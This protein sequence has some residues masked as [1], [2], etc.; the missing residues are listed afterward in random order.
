MN[1]KLRI[2]VDILMIAILVFI[3]QLTKKWAVNTLK[4][5]DP[6]ILI[7]GV[8]QLYYLP[9]GNTG[10]AF[11][12]LSGHRVL[13]LFIAAAVVAVIL[14]LLI[15]LPMDSRF[16]V[17][18]ILLIFIAAGGIGN[19]IDRF[20][21]TYVIDFIYFYLINFPIFNVADCY[22]TVATIALALLILF[23]YKEEDMK[24]LEQSVLKKDKTGAAQ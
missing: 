3:D 9:S 11:G 20:V 16:T 5:S 17:L 6:V 12:I 13:F 14:F 18:R 19:M 10:A 22:V 23:R 2:T 24:L 7:K 8:L 4:D 15:R 1:R 21:L